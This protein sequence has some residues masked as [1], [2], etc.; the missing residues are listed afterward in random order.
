MTP[1]DMVLRNN[2]IYYTCQGF[3][4]QSSALRQDRVNSLE[5]TLHC[6]IESAFLSK[7]GD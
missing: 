5:V 6:A 3:N 2:N 7:L 4:F 1:F